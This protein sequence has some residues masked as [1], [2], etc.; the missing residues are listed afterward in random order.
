MLKF[1]PV[2]AA[3]EPSCPTHCAMGTIGNSDKCL[4]NIQISGAT[5]IRTQSYC[6]RSFCPY[7]TAEFF[8]K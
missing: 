7:P 6:L 4:G 1:E 5:E 2:P 8:L 3:S